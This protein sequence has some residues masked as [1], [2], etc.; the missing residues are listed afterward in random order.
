MARRDEVGVRLREREAVAVAGHSSRLPRR[1]CGSTA[2]PDLGPRHPP[3]AAGLAR[4]GPRH[5]RVGPS[6]RALQRHWRARSASPSPS[7]SMTCAT[8]AV[9]FCSWAAAPARAP[10]A[11]RRTHATT[12]PTSSRPRPATPARARAPRRSAGA[13]RGSSWN[14]RTRATKPRSSTMSSSSAGAGAGRA[15]IP[16]R[17]RRGLDPDTPRRSAPRRPPRRRWCLRRPRAA[18]TARERTTSHGAKRMRDRV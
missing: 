4:P 2:V 14:T 13:H 12:P 9:V 15:T 11:A 17:R 16:P 10:A 8:R 5:A 7:T 3:P 1:R 18:A 6:R